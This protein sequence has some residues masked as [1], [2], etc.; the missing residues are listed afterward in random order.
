MWNSSATQKVRA[1]ECAPGPVGTLAPLLAHLLPLFLKSRHGRHA[2][3]GQSICTYHSC[4]D[5]RQ[6]RLGNPCHHHTPSAGGC[7]AHFDTGSWRPHRCDRWLPAKQERK[8]VKASFTSVAPS[9]SGADRK[10]GA[11]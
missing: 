1:H 11:F 8:M 7:S 5:P 9:P 6:S 2:G 10:G 4:P 3:W